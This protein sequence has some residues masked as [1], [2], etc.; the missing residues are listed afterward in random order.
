M[1][2]LN[3]TLRNVVIESG[4]I[5]SFHAVILPGGQEREQSIRTRWCTE[6]GAGD[7][8]FESW[9]RRCIFNLF[10]FFAQMKGILKK[11]NK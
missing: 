1:T 2:R 5:P 10:E 6:N 4:Y 7:S 3:S 8:N 9:F 11:K